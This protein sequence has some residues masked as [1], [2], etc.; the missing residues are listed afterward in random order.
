MM[1]RESSV[2]WKSVLWSEPWSAG[3]VSARRMGSTDS[4]RL[5]GTPK[6]HT[7]VIWRVLKWFHRVSDVFHIRNS[8]LKVWSHESLKQLSRWWLHGA[9]KQPTR[10]WL[11]CSK[12]TFH[13]AWFSFEPQL[14]STRVC[15]CALKLAFCVCSFRWQTVLGSSWVSKYHNNS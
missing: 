10:A 13:N 4:T 1:R 8:L 11:L 7:M 14:F 3:T 6:L 12:C 15:R 2:T 5:T 9:G